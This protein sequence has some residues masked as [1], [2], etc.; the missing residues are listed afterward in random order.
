VFFRKKS[1]CVLFQNGV[2][3]IW[4]KKTPWFLKEFL[5]SALRKFIEPTR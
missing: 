4:R 3:K 2:K 1:L 5:S